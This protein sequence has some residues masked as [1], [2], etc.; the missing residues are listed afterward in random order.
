M[1]YVYLLK[2]LTDGKHY[3][4][5]TDDIDERLRRHNDGYVAATRGRRPLVLLGHESFLS[6]D[7]A[8]YREFSLKKSATERKK[9]YEKFEK[10]E[11]L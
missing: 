8:R 6:R 7:E 5:Q 11:L 3:I 2:S 10:T 4:G 9:F 1:F